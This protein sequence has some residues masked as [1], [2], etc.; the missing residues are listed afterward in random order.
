MSYPQKSNERILLKNLI[1]IRWIA[2]TG[3]LLAI[4]VV[5]FFLN[6]P[7]PLLYC[8]LIIVISILINFLSLF[9]KS[10]SNYLSEY[11]AF[12]FLLYDTIQLAILLYLTGGIYNPFCLFLI[13]PVIISASHLKISYSVFL[14]IF[15]IFIIFLL[16]FFYIEI[17]WPENFFVPKLFTSGLVLAL[18]I[19]IIFIAVYVYILSNSSRKLSNALN[20]TQIALIN[21]KKVSEIGSLAAAAAHEMSTPLNTIF[22]ILGDLKKDKTINDDLKSDILLLKEQA[23]RCKKILLNLSK[24]P[25]NLKDSFLKKIK[26]SNLVNL[27]FEKFLKNNKNLKIS[28]KTLHEEEEPLINYSDEIMYGLGNIIQNAIE[29]SREKINVNIS[30]SNEFIFISVQDD[31]KGFTNEIL[32]RIGNPYISNKDNEDSMGLGIF[33][34]KN[35]IENIGGSMKFFN[36]TDEVGSVVE[37]SLIRST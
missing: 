1:S 8:L 24:N 29:H 26:I 30:W 21:Q 10:R 28:V 6:I 37:I 35:L 16:S 12:Y 2:I 13:A 36:K 9:P 7:I 18:V 33:I 31:G 17:I 19:A 32:E 3:Q 23:N 27:S 15:S 4:I 5:N 20:Q 34:A 11:E 25:Q 14:S 22:L